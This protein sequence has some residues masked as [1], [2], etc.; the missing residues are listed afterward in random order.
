MYCEVNCDYWIFFFPVVL[1]DMWS[2]FCVCVLFVPALLASI[3]QKISLAITASVHSGLSL[4]TQ[5]ISVET[6]EG[7]FVV[8]EGIFLH[9]VPADSGPVYAKAPG[10]ACLPVLGS[11]KLFDVS[12]PF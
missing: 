5:S 11:V 8:S 1:F 6:L 4:L 12:L 7:T 10:P 9:S 2:P 3:V